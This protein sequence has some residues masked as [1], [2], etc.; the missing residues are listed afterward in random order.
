[1]PGNSYS[2]PVVVG[3]KLYVY[4]TS[5]LCC[6]DALTGRLLWQHYQVNN[7]G[8]QTPWVEE[9]RIFTSDN[10]RTNSLKAFDATN[11]TLLWQSQAVSHT[12]GSPVGA[13]IHGVRQ[14]LFP[15][16]DGVIA[17]SPDTGKALWSYRTNSLSN[18]G[19]SP[20]ALGNVVLIGNKT[21]ALQI[22]YSNGL[23]KAKPAWTNSHHGAYYTTIVSNNGCAFISAG[24]YLSCRE[25]ETGRLNWDVNWGE[26]TVIMA[27]GYLLHTGFDSSLILANSTPERY[28]EI[29]RCPQLS[30][31]TNPPIFDM[32]D[33]LNTPAY[34][35]GYLFVRSVFGTT[36]VDLDPQPAV[37]LTLAATN[38]VAQL[39][40]RPGNGWDLAKS[41][42]TNLVLLCT[43]NPALPL[44]E[45]TSAGAMTWKN[46]TLTKRLVLGSEEPACYYQITTQAH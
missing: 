46:G 15:S 14:I 3:E 17:V 5:S 40:V 38:Q 23:F 2:T 21:M 29:C 32:S 36:C 30:R 10:S 25:I 20:V 27:N 6:L 41:R 24:G 11:G 39:S 34:A 43:T 7:G 16:S 28:E 19:P 44:S 26:G 9:G 8:S 33:C 18:N 22:I 37:A 12:Y 42:A 1:M 13:T 45:W 31:L 4:K 35:N